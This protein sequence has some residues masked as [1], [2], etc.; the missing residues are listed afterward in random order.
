MK[1]FIYMKLALFLILSGCAMHEDV[2]LLDS[3]LSYLEKHYNALESMNSQLN[4]QVNTKSKNAQNLRVQFAEFRIMHNQ[5]KE[6]LQSVKGQLEEI[7]FFLK[8]Q[9]KNINELKSAYPEKISYLNQ[10]LTTIS[11]H[12]NEIEQYLGL[13]PSKSSSAK[14]PSTTQEVKKKALTDDDLYAIAKQTFDQGDFET[15]RTQFQQLIDRFPKSKNADNAQF[16]IGETHYRQKWY[17]KA[18]L[19]Y[20]KV[21][22]KYPKG[23]KVPSA[24]LKQAF[25]FHNIKENPNARHV[26][27]ELIRRFPKSNEASIAQKKITEFK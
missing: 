27:N 2:L 24:L 21:I 16:W 9:I 18:I 3:R 14:Q 23:N 25:S 22:D 10:K 12:V 1:K 19:E 4:T 17:E 15:S 8:N 7:D 13:E 26:L 6:E 20:Q 11:K 5:M